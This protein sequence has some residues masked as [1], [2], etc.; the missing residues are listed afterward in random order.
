MSGHV[1][2]FE[3]TVV[4]GK[5]RKPGVT[6]LAMLPIHIILIVVFFIWLAPT[7]GLLVSS[8][9][10]ANLIQTSGWW[11]AFSSPLSF[12]LDNY[13]YVIQRSGMGRSFFNSLMITI[14]STV[15]PI[16][17]AAF[18]AYALS[19][20]NFR[21]RDVLLLLFVALIVIPLQMTFIPILRLFNRL[22]L[23]GTFHGIWIAHAAYGLPFAI[24]LLRGFIGSLPGEIFESAY[25]DGASHFQVFYRLV[26]PTS[27][28]AIASLTIFQFMWTWNDL[29]IA[30]L[31]LG[32]GRNVAPM[33]V[34][35]S[36]LVNSYGSGWHYLTAAA[37]I[38][39]VMP[40]LVFLF[41][42]RYF[43]KGITAGAVKG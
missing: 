16:L 29:L 23:T 43:V 11:R 3:S 17:A 24:Y 19:W 2:K 18:A 1:S 40:L 26:L 13:S 5:G 35:V 25:I 39:M 15:L 30:L 41:L 28:P 37:F 21:G 14:P 7:L 6:F 4:K 27:V 34:T 9:R 20:M 32:G 36:N 33:T 38:S 22:N 31:Y 10:P 42:Q 12:T 8:F